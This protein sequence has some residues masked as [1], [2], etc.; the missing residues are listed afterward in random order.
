MNYVNLN[1][2]FYLYEILLYYYFFHIKFNISAT[3]F[4]VAHIIYVFIIFGLY[5]PI[6]VDIN[7]YIHRF[8]II[9]T[10]YFR[11]LEYIHNFPVIINYDLINNIT[12]NFIYY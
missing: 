7:F 3:I 10:L 1:I 5:Y 9:L 8:S 6:Y 4:N 11:R 12:N 2:V